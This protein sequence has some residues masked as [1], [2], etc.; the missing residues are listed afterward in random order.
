MPELVRALHGVRDGTGDARRK[1]VRRAVHSAH[2]TVER[3]S[4]GVRDGLAERLARAHALRN[5]AGARADRGAA[6]S[7]LFPGLDRW[8]M[9]KRVYQL[10]DEAGVR[11]VCTHSLRGLH[12]SLATE[13][14][15]TAEMVARQLGHAGTAVTH[16]H[17]IAPAATAT[18]RAG[19]VLGVIRGGRS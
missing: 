19:R 3:G 17:Y 8:R 7:P 6:E 11:R 12:G 10:C 13:T 15:A 9:L 1:E 4:A 5:A 16:G 18:A 14:G 2:T